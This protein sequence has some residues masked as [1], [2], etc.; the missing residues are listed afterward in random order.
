MSSNRPYPNPASL[1]GSQL[2]ADSDKDFVILQFGKVRIFMNHF[3]NQIKFE[4]KGASNKH[5]C[6]IPD[7]SHGLHESRMHHDGS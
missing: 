6:S 3:R 7:R 1:L 5:E 4:C 2:V